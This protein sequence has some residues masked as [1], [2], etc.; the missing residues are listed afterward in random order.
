[1]DT[2]LACLLHCV[3]HLGGEVRLIPKHLLISSDCMISQVYGDVPHRQRPVGGSIMPRTPSVKSLS[4]GGLSSPDL[5]SCASSHHASSENGNSSCAY[6]H[7]TSSSTSS[8][9]S[10]AGAEITPAP[11]VVSAGVH[12]FTVGEV[13]LDA[14]WGYRRVIQRKIT[15][16]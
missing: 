7:G 12:H 9:G 10:S 2:L 5:Y 15:Y 6:S 16:F 3:G 1:M 8:S 11:M 14:T 4:G 13:R